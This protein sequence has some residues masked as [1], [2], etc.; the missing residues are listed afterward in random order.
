MNKFFFVGGFSAA[1]W[2]VSQ[3]RAS[4]WLKISKQ[5]S[6]KFFLSRTNLKFQRI[7]RGN[8][9][10]IRS[11]YSANRPISTRIAANAEFYPLIFI[12]P[13]IFPFFLNL[14]IKSYYCLFL[15]QKELIWTYCKRGGW[16]RFDLSWMG[17]S[18][19]WITSRKLFNKFKSH[20]FQ[21][22]WRRSEGAFP[23]NPITTNFQNKPS[24]VNK[25]SS[26]DPS[27]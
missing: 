20:K 25:S 8:F 1:N 17:S 18:T 26:S 13:K 19:N 21:T 10:P 9:K 22:I 12:F 23:K 27:S 2:P 15:L 4:D 6:S 3:I 5:N 16:F 7:W 14:I 24:Y 11:L